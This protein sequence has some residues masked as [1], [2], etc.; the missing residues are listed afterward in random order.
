MLTWCSHQKMKLC[1][2]MHVYFFK[3]NFFTHMKKQKNYKRYQD[4]ATA[5][6]GNITEMLALPK[7]AES[8]LTCQAISFY[9]FRSFRHFLDF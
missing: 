4:H 5:T 2:H 9:V 6:D 1:P 3:E 7:L 8:C